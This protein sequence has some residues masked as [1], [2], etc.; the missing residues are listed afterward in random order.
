MK[1]KYTFDD[2]QKSIKG[3]TAVLT[4]VDFEHAL[5]M[6]K[7]SPFNLGETKMSKYYI[8]KDGKC[9]LPEGRGYTA[10]RAEAGIFA[11]P[12]MEKFNL[13]GCTLEKAAS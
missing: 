10:K 8:L 5:A 7:H 3:T 4:D 11:L 2:A 12:E 13:D 1:R 9:W 6:L